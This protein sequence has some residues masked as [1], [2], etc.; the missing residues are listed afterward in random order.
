MDLAAVLRRVVWSSI[1][2]GIVSGRV[3]FFKINFFVVGFRLILVWSKPPTAKAFYDYAIPE[4]IENDVSEFYCL[5]KLLS[6]YWDLEQE[7][8][9]GPAAV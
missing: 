8:Y 7:D 5:V 1:S 3:D 4:T 6:G 2:T 9:E